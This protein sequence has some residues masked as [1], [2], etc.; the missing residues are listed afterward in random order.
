MEDLG[1]QVYRGEGLG[2]RVLGLGLGGQ[3]LKLGIWDDSQAWGFHSTS[4]SIPNP[5]AKTLK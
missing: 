1:F 2:S 3:C 4:K 5:E